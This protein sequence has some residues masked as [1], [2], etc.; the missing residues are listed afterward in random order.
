MKNYQNKNISVSE[1]RFRIKK[2]KVRQM[3]TS[4][5]KRNFAFLFTV[6]FAALFFVAIFTG[7]SGSGGETPTDR[8]CRL[9]PLNPKFL[10]YIDTCSS[11]DG[12]PLGGVPSP[13]DLSH[14]RGSVDNAVN[15]DY[16]AYYDL[17]SLGLVTPIKNQANYPTCWI[18]AAFASLESCLLPD[19]VVD[20][21]E[22]HMAITHGFDYGVQD[23]GNSFMT[24]A[25]FLR[26]SGPVLETEVT[27]G[28]VLFVS[29]YI[30]PAKHVQQ[31]VF[32]PQREGPLDNN[33]VKYFIMNYG[34]VDFAYNWEF[35]SF[36]D[37]TNSMYTPNNGGE[38]HRLAIVGWDDNYP[39]DRFR[40]RPAGN[41]A[42]ICRNSWGDTW[43]ERGYC[44]ISYYDLS[45]VNFTCFNNAEEPV[46][47][48][49]IYQYDP[50]GYTRTWGK[51][52]SWGANVFTAENS[53]PLEAVGFYAVDAGMNYE[54]D[55]YK[56]VDTAAANPASG[57]LA[58]VKTGTFV[59]AGYY[60][61]KLDNLIP[62][63]QGE[64]FSI[65]V[66]FKSSTY[67]YSVPIEAPIAHHSSA[68]S[69]NPGESYVS[70]DGLQ[71][72]DFTTVVPG[73]NVCIKAYS[74]YKE[75]NVSLEATRKTLRGWIVARDYADIVVTV[76]NIEE[77]PLSKL[78]LYRSN[79]SPDF[80]LLREIAPDEL[81]NGR[82]DYQDRYLGRSES[83]T[84]QVVA[85]DRKGLISSKSNMVTL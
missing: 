21:S 38:N 29:R 51:Q 20:F 34:P 49:T 73:S 81:V 36:N 25:Y 44:Y 43:G 9:A 50:L 1:S 52:E 4:L 58:A 55:I 80:E 31:V 84:Y 41:G 33:T 57:I 3:K 54:I 60:T 66:K 39:A 47:Y 77:V 71:W 64:H 13:V 28:S 76:S 69:A 82:F 14:I 70:E 11:S 12:Y 65:V 72:D 79:N 63:A 10:K 42:F 30:V 16:P 67:R 59:Y 68:A 85:V 46:N 18:F 2:R 22:W 75:S 7:A 27:Y 83:S 61:V 6:L 40:Y 23:A 32:L 74:E 78:L 17:R 15:S 24:T 26:W 37:S 45:F 19:Q 53:E 48:G 8:S 56:N 62:L 5:K 35:G